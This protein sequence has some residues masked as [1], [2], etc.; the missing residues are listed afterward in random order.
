MLKS[1]PQPYYYY[2]LSD[3]S[4]MSGRYFASSF[5]YSII[6]DLE[7]KMKQ[8]FGLFAFKYLYVIVSSFGE[9]KIRISGIP[10]HII[11]K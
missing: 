11:T 2:L 6:F 7:D 8:I 9:P 1:S 10:T 3:E 4:G 5:L